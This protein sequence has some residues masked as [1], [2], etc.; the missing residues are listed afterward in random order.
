[1]ADG[2]DAPLGPGSRA[3]SLTASDGVR[4]RGAFLSGGARGLVLLLQGRTEFCEKYAGVA[5]AFAQRG[6]DVATLDWRGQGASQR[7]VGHPRK[8]HV[9]DFAEFQR[10]L[11]ALLAAAPV[12]GHAGPRVMAAHSMGGAIG[13][14]ALIDGRAPVSAAIFC[15]P[16]WGLA[17]GRLAGLAGRALSAAAVALGMGRA[18]APGGG[19]ASYAASDP[20]PNVLTSD[21]DQAAWLAALTRAHADKALGGATLGWAHA[22]YREMAALAPL[23]LSVPSLVVAGGDEAVTSLRAMRA[24]A[25]RD[26]LRMVEIA[27]GRHELFF[28]TPARRAQFW[29]AIDAFLRDQKL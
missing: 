25:A 1:M 29:A 17:Q 8:G 22:A 7:P 28:E 19:D 27:G 15:A 10:D 26:G 2:A 4:L 24:R 12:A 6:F 20:Q 23:P 21:P 3:L 14:R 11:A 9:D 16:M 5:A 18:Y 13:L